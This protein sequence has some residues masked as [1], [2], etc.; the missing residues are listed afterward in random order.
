LPCQPKDRNRLGTVGD[1]GFPGVRRPGVHNVRSECVRAVG[2]VF[3]ELH[4]AIRRFDAANLV[5]KRSIGK[6]LRDGRF[7]GPVIPFHARVSDVLPLFAGKDDIQRAL[8]R[9]GE[10]RK[11][12]PRLMPCALAS[13]PC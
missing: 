7:V 10:L 12:E 8:V 4:R 6:I 1:G 2:R 9:I 13:D 5:R 3:E 11:V